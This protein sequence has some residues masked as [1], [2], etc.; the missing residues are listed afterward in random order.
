MSDTTTKGIKF[1]SSFLDGSGYGKFGR[2][3]LKLLIKKNIPVSTGI[4]TFEKENQRPNLGDY[5]KQIEALSEVNI[6]SDIILSALTPDIAI[7]F[8]DPSKVNI[9]WFFWECQEGI[10]PLWADCLQKFDA[11]ITSCESAKQ[12][13]I[14]SGI[15]TPI[16]VVPVN[17]EFNKY[18]PKEKP[19]LDDTY[20]FYS[21]FQWQERK[22][23]FGLLK[24]YFRAFS[25]K[26]NVMLVLKTYLTR[27]Q[28]DLNQ[29]D[30]IKNYLNGLKQ[31]MQFNKGFPKVYLITDV[32]SDEEIE[33]MHNEL[34]CYVS[35]D[36][37]EGWS[38]PC[39][40]AMLAGNPV[41]IPKHTSYLD[42]TN[43]DLVYY[44]E[45]QLEPTFGLTPFYPGDICTF[46]NP[47]ILEGAERMRYVFENREEA[48]E[49]GAK[50]REYIMQNFNEDKVFNTFVKSIIDIVKSKR[51]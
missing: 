43:E 4:V 22:N 49:K 19:N 30:M 37:G 42:Y 21:I 25:D 34:D 24:A 17:M 27:M 26:D 10:H 8:I 39:E 51:R 20:N 47:S 9:N 41:I 29:Q 23:P 18:I 1:H 36:R 12:C 38:L 40:N 28:N 5:G 2:D 48:F 44:I 15:Q 13:L 46:F 6:Q 11:I 35:M 31:T 7:R 50:S 16:Y 3:F 32:L 14:S 45:G 33:N